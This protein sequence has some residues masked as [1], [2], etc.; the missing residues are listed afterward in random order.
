[1]HYHMVIQKNSPTNNILQESKSVT[2]KNMKPHK[3]CK[4]KTMKTQ[5]KTTKQKNTIS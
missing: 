2:Q 4:W 5:K 1:M 3:M